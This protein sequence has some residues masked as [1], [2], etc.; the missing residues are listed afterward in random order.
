[1][2]SLELT[3]SSALFALVSVTQLSFSLVSRQAGAPRE[4]TYVVS[5]YQHDGPL[6]VVAKQ[7]TLILNLVFM[8][9]RLVVRSWRQNAV[10]GDISK[11]HKQ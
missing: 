6:G 4:L 8:T 3:R 7:G 11:A 9:R 5:G 10:V 1:M 2:S